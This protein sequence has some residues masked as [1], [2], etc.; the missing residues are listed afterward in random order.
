MLQQTDDYG[1]L[2]NDDYQV[3]VAVLTKENITLKTDCINLECQI[4]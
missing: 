3:L 4:I 1:Q 2:E